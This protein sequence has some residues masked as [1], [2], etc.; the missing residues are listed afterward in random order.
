MI[1]NDTQSLREKAKESVHFLTKKSL[2]FILH[3]FWIFPLNKNRISLINEQSFTYGDNLKYINKYLND[4][5]PGRYEVVFPVKEGSEPALNAI[6]VKPLSFRYFKL[7]ISSGTVFTNCGGLSYLPKRKGQQFI[8]TWHGGGAYK[9]V[10]TDVWDTPFSRAEDR[11]NANNTDFL[12]SSC[13]AFIEAE[14]EPMMFRRE[15][16]LKT[17]LPRNDIFF[18][19]HPDIKDKVF[20]ELGLLS[21]QRLVVYAPTYRSDVNSFANSKNARIIDV[22]YQNVID[23]LKSKFGGDW[24]FGIRLHPRLGSCDFEDKKVVNCTK[25]PDMQELLYASDAVITDYSS[26]MWDFSLTYRPCFI[27]APDIDEYERDRGFYTPVARWP[28]PITKTNEQLIEAIENF[29]VEKYIELVKEHH[30]YMKSYEK[31]T[32]CKSAI[33]LIRN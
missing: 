25:Y 21:N 22:E 15:Q 32:A 10:G 13:G 23:A 28:F 1:D 17:G 8:N 7:V 3:F 27:Y 33:D 16:C 26:L 12:F 18:E 6:T 19:N 2:H 30:K 9:K 11:M 31:G 5:C 20:N 4:N 24:K 14:A 29:S